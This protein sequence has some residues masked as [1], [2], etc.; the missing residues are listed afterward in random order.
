[1]SQL[2]IRGKFDFSDGSSCPKSA[3]N[4]FFVLEMLNKGFLHFLPNVWCIWWFFKVE[5]TEGS[6]EL[7]KNHQICQNLAK[8]WRKT[9]F[10]LLLTTVNS[11]TR[12]VT[13]LL[14]VYTIYIIL[15]MMHI[16]DFT[17][18]LVYLFYIKTWILHRTQK[19]TYSNFF[20]RYLLR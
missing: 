18:F 13:T 17:M 15:K 3:E 8:K 19:F 20:I 2:Q 5:C 14:T 11:D 4:G 12:F 6:A 9:L 1:M 16:C 10:N 7:W